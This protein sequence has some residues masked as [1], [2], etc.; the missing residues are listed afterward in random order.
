MA[1]VGNYIVGLQR[2]RES[3]WRKRPRWLRGLLREVTEDGKIVESS[4]V[5]PLTITVIRAVDMGWG[6]PDNWIMDSL[7]EAD[8]RDEWIFLPQRAPSKGEMRRK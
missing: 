8:V 4:I 2:E 1:L 7:V 3:E 6:C 5:I